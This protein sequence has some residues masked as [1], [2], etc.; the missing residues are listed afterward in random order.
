MDILSRL[1]DGLL[2][3][4]GGFGSLL[5]ARGLKSGQIPDLWNLDNPDAVRDAH[6]EYLR[7]GADI[8][9]TNTFGANRDRL[10]HRF[11]ETVTAGVNLA[12]EAVR[13][14]GGGF[15]ALDI[16]PTG[17]MFEPFGELT[18]PHALEL[19]SEAVRLGA[20]AGADLVNIETM[21]D[22]LEAKAA[23]IAAKENCSLPVFV[24][25]A[26][27]DKGKLLMG[28]DALTAATLLEALGA[29]AVG[30]NCGVS[31]AGALKLTEELASCL[32]VP[33]IVCPNAGMPR[34]REGRACY[35]VTPA[36][37][38]DTMARIVRAGARVIGGCCGTTPA[39]IAA[40]RE[41][42]AGEKPVPLKDKKRTVVSSSMQAF[43]LGETPAL[44][45]NAI[46]PN[47]NPLVAAAFLSGD[48]GAAV[49]E[50]VTQAAEE[51]HLLSVSAK[52]DG[53]NERELLAETVT[54]VQTVCRTPLVLRTTELFAAERAL[55]AYN[56]RPLW[57]YETDAETDKAFALAKKYGAVIAVPTL[58]GGTVP[59]TA[60]G[61]LK[62]AGELLKA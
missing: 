35:D 26:F 58:S 47:L 1:Q 48:T 6:L 33:V 13:E 54:D 49:D 44:V 27:G 14:N 61:R 51:A 59:E 52:K 55:R 60:Q 34:I 11:E 37:F 31:P 8:I 45:G 19:F 42:T 18:F 32:S 12:K 41:R 28:S 21:G 53:V 17:R 3:F 4:D 57:Y 22:L 36:D 20:A 38:A 25:V 50:A 2:Y 56:G 62:A 24:S 5:Q 15:V 40:L 23:V 46:D 7:A 29:D 10:G 43:E 30:L 9:N 16:G 39:Q